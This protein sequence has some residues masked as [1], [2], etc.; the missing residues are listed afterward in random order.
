MEKITKHNFGRFIKENF[1]KL[2]RLSKGH[3][4]LSVFAILLFFAI[5]GSTSYMLIA[6]NKS[7][8]GGNFFCPYKVYEEADGN[9]GSKGDGPEWKLSNE[10]LKWIKKNCKDVVWTSKEKESAEGKKE[11]K[12]EKKEEKALSG[13][14]SYVPACSSTSQYTVLP[15]KETDFYGIWPLGNLNPS[16]HTFPTDHIYLNTMDSDFWDASKQRSV[17]VYAPGDIWITRISK[18]DNQT[19]GVAD[20]DIEYYLCKDI[21]GKFGHVGNLSENIL[22]KLQK[23]ERCTEYTTGGKTFKRCEY[24]L[25]QEVKAGEKVG[26]AG[27]GQSGMLDIWAM[28]FRLKPIEFANPKRWWTDSLYIAC[29]ADHF[30]AELKGILMKRFRG[31]NN[32]TRT[33][34]PVCGT[35]D[36]DVKGTAQG[37]W[38]PPGVPEEPGNEDQNLALAFDNRETE[39]QVFSMGTSGESKGF[40]GGVYFFIPK[41]TGMINRDFSTVKPDGKVYCYDIETG[42]DLSYQAIRKSAILL[43]MP[44]EK[45]VRVEKLGS[46]NCGDGPWSMKNYVEFAR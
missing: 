3:K 15:I 22:S 25:G 1:S 16:S 45:T 41:N 13:A 37:V 31:A 18:S 24:E 35:I 33:K 34:E 27:D 11:K 43:T 29:P 30:T 17:S 20:Y 8:K 28:D 4:L 21:K 7:G 26:T 40:S 42:R 38:F 5:F 23:P 12:E 2:H 10:E 32:V 39:K 19:T 36:V 44:D 6:G 46:P 9:Y 14:P